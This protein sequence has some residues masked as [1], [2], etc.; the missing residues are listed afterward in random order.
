MTDEMIKLNDEKVKTIRR[1][2][3]GMMRSSDMMFNDHI[4]G[5]KDDDID[6]MELIAYLYEIIHQLYYHEPYGYMFHWA[7]KVGAWVDEKNIE[8]IINDLMEEENEKTTK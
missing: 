2:I 7:N 4:R 8:I 5:E 6:L 1:F 3:A